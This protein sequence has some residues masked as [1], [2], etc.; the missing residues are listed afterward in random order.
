[1]HAPA[2]LSFSGRLIL[3]GATPP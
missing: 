1:M 3:A 2:P